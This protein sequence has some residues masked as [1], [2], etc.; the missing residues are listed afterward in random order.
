MSKIKVLVNLDPDENSIP[1]LWMA[2]FLLYHHMI[3]PLYIMQMGGETERQKQRE[4]HFSSFYKV[5]NSILLR[6]TPHDL[7]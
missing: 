1:A 3:F 2:T 4:G 7:I 5:I 6:S